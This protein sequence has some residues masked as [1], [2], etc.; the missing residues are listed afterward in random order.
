MYMFSLIV[1]TRTSCVQFQI[2]IDQYKKNLGS[3]D[4]TNHYC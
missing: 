4:F 1:L 2:K 3:K